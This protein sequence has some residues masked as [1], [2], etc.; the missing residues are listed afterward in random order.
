MKGKISLYTEM[1]NVARF[2]SR[3]ENPSKDLTAQL[4]NILSDAIVEVVNHSTLQ[5]RAEFI[6]RVSELGLSYKSEA[7]AAAV[8]SVLNNFFDVVAAASAADLTAIAGTEEAEDA[9]SEGAASD[10]F[11]E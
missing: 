9:E 4:R 3:V 1:P 2:R 6:K 11:E 8:A 7:H 5:I 10:E